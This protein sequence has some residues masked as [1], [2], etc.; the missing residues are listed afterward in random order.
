MTPV[1]APDLT[2]E[3]VAPET[4]GLRE[5]VETVADWCEEQAG[6]RSHF[7]KVDPQYRATVIPYEATAE[8]LRAAL[9]SHTPGGEK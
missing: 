2:G 5:R 4:D 6:S 8:R 1:P 3:A 9:A 7:A